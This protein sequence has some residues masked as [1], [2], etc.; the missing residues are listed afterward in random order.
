MDTRSNSSDDSPI[1]DRNGPCEAP[2]EIPNGGPCKAAAASDGQCKAVVATPNLVSE[3]QIANYPWRKQKTKDFHSKGAWK[4]KGGKGKRG[5]GN[6]GKGKS[7]KGNGFNGKG[8]GQRT[9]MVLRSGKAKDQRKNNVRTSVTLIPRAANPFNSKPK[10][11]SKARNERRKKQR[12]D[13]ATL[14]ADVDR[15]PHMTVA[16]ANTRGPVLSTQ[17]PG[18]EVPQPFGGYRSGDVIVHGQAGWVVRVSRNAK[19]GKRYQVGPRGD[20]IWVDV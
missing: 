6:G 13:G 5:K 7:G 3:Q 19:P 10:Q 11:S 14:V 16:C 18:S 1:V 9:Q 20:V 4:S 2:A 12:N 8:K 17:L 15:Q